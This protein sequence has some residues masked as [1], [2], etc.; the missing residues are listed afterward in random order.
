M[1]IIKSAVAVMA[2]FWLQTVSDSTVPLI[3][4]VSKVKA[5][6]AVNAPTC[7]VASDNRV[8]TTPIVPGVKVAAVVNAETVLAVLDIPVTVPLIAINGSF[9]V[10]GPAHTPIVTYPLYLSRLKTT[11]LSLLVHFS[12]HSP[13]VSSSPSVSSFAVV[14]DQPRL[15]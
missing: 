3:R 8:T 7:Q 6:A 4:I 11:L 13:L 2:V 1:V 10:T 9:V 5:A 15:C 12:V 14:K